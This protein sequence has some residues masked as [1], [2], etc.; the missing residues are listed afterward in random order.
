M[1]NESTVHTRELLLETATELFAEHGYDAV[2]TRMIA[3]KAKVNLGGIHYH[4]GSKEALYIEAFRSA[5][6]ASGSLK[7]E[8]IIRQNPELMKTP[9]GQ[10]EIVRRKVFDHFKRYFRVDDGAKRKMILREIY[11]KSSANQLLI[12]TVFKPENE[13]LIRF[14]QRIRPEKT[15]VESY[16]W[17]LFLPTQTA[18]YLLARNSL[19]RTY[20]RHFVYEILPRELARTSAKVL[21]F[22]LGLPI[23]KDMEDAEIPHLTDPEGDSASSMKK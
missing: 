15:Y 2:S 8:D 13:D 22:L 17:G 4:F 7:T 19:E 12:D 5:A 11:Q 18:F 20:D 16:V 21:I 10:A 3:E 23:P 6:D 9:E 14:F 1:K